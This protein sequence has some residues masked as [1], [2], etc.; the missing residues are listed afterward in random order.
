[1]LKT[2]YQSVIATLVIALIFCGAY[3]LIV[4]ALGQVLFHD[5]ANGSLILAADGKA[6]G[7]A[8]IGQAFTKPEYFH[9]RPSA[10]GSGY[11]AS[12][13][14]GS[15]LGPTHQKLADGL[16]SNVDGFLKDNPTVKKGEVP[17]DAVTA[18]GSGLDPHI[19]PQNAVAQVSRVAASRGVS[20]DQIRSLI[21]EHT[22]GPQLGFLGESVVNVLLINRDL[23]EKF[24][25]KK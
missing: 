6:V 23:D 13:S 18:S 11:D 25:M 8:L 7:S 1:M 3:P 20:G 22:E 16:K 15:N 24:A 17:P 12:N 19:T 21:Q 10:A 9:S 14:S 4:T 2:L 5:K